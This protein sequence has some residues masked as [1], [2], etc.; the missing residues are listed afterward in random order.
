MLTRAGVGA[1]DTVLITGASGGVGSAAI[2]L[3]KARGASVI[4]VTSPSKAD[5]LIAL[6]A[7][8][9]VSRNDYLPEAMGHNSVDVVIDLVAGP[10]WS[11]LLDVLRFK[12]RYAVSGAIAG[13]T[14]ELDVRTLY[15]KDLSFFGCTVLEPKVFPN[16][17]KRI[18][19]QEINPLV[20]HEFTL[21]QITEAQEKFQKKSH[22]GKIVLR[23]DN[24]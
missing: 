6:G 9:T 16:L 21:S 19:R 10:G 3:A 4:A 14:V 15:L 1:D 22:V 12:G 7:D 23:V 20:A 13:P 5:D 11:Q 24:T 17:V 18:E 8:K 2:Q